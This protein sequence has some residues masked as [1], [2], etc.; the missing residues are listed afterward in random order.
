VPLLGS[1]I[2]THDVNGVV[3]GLKDFPPQDRAPA[4]I[5]FF[6]FRIMVGAGLIMLALVAVG[7]W[8]RLRRRL[9]DTGWFLWALHLVC[10][11]GLHCRGRRL[12]HHRSRPPAW[13]VYG[14]M[15]T[16][17]SVTPSLT[18]IDVLVSLLGYVTVYLIMFPPACGS[19]LALFVASISG[20]S[21]TRGSR[22]SGPSGQACARNSVKSRAMIIFDFVRCGH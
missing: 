8:L 6:S 5:P 22:P 20:R 12:D 2:L 11:P 10:I 9:Y 18:G 1:L 3:P 15:R 17:H 7:L 13:T 16:A 4:I 14:V 21:H 19:S